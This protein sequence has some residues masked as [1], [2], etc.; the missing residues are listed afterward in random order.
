MENT[1]SATIR[2]R[3]CGDEITSKHRHDYV[4]CSCGDLAIDGG[5]DYTR[6]SFKT[7]QDGGKGYDVV[8]GSLDGE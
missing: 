3:N 5:N 8:V 4:R 1:V 6:I 2:C 7:E